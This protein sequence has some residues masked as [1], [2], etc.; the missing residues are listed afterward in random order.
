MRQSSCLVFGRRRVRISTT[1]PTA[2]TFLSLLTSHPIISQLITHK[3][4]YRTLWAT[5]SVS[6]YITRKLKFTLPNNKVNIRKFASVCAAEM[7]NPLYLTSIPRL[8][9]HLQLR[10]L[11]PAGRP[12]RPRTQHDYHDDTK[13]KP[14]AATAVTELLMMGG[15]TPETCWAVNNVRIINWKTVA[16][17]LWFIWIKCKTPVPKG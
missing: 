14:E 1:M 6:R 13:I 4:S 17:G 11:L 8:I 15:K 12:A 5:G 10:N 2:P 16:S 7:S 9:E 3:L